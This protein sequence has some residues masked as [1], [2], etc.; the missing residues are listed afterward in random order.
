MSG[1]STRITP[2]EWLER[3]FHIWKPAAAAWLERVLL[4]YFAGTARFRR[5]KKETGRVLETRTDG[6]G[7]F[8]LWLDCAREMRE[9]YKDR[10][11]VLILDSTKPTAELARR[12]GYFDEVLEVGIHNY[13]RFATI[14]RMRRMSFDLVL[15]PV[16]TRLLFT[17]ILLFACRARERITLDTNGKFFTERTLKVSNRGYD[18]ILP[19][20]PGVR[21]ELLRGA[22]FLRG[23]GFSEYRAKLPWLPPM[24]ENPVQAKDY[25]V[26]FPAASWPG[27]VWGYERFAAVCDEIIDQTGYTCVAAGGRADLHTIGSMISCMRHGREVFNAAGIFSICQTAEAIRGARLALGNDTGPMHM[28]V[29]CGTPSV[30]ITGDLE[31]GRFFPYEAEAAGGRYPRVAAAALPCRGCQTEQDRPCP[32][33]TDGRGAVRCITAVTVESCMEAVTELLEQEFTKM[34]TAGKAE[35]GGE[36]WEKFQKG[37]HGS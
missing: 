11:I 32:Y 22:Q 35:G 10:T 1:I 17:D 12:T 25:I 30:V 7:D 28:A 37:F 5:S 13:T 15:Q 16:Y 4:W 34:E 33:P 27:K 29:A 6:L 36:R 23:L 8:I 31:Y 14:L 24:G 26:V 21:H 20:A 3:R 18:R 2:R 9:R 19:A